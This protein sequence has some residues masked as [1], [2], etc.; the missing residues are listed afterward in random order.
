MRSNETPKAVWW[1]AALMF[2]AAVG[3]CLII[4]GIT[5]ITSGTF[6]RG[7]RE[8]IESEKEILEGDEARR[9]GWPMIAFGALLMVAE[10]YIVW[11]YLIEED[12]GI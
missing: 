1:L 11:R 5:A 12:D 4:P 9:Q 6:Q 10:G 7:V 2:A 3:Y 8:G